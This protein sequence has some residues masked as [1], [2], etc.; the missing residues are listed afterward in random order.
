MLHQRLG[1]WI[2]PLQESLVFSPAELVFGHTVWGPLELFHDQ[3]LSKDSP[4]V[5]ILE[6]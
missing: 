5:P 2:A 6:Y 1:G 4:R 3:F